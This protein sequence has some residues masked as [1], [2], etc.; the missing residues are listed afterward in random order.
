MCLLNVPVL[1]LCSYCSK[2]RSYRKA[3]ADTHV[4][5]C[6]VAACL[7]VNARATPSH[8]KPFVT[9]GFSVTYSIS[10]KLTNSQ[11]LTEANATK[12][13]ATKIAAQK[14][15]V[16]KTDARFGVRAISVIRANPTRKNRKLVLKPYPP[17]LHFR[18]KVRNDIQKALNIACFFQHSLPGKGV[19]SLAQTR[20]ANAAR[21]VSFPTYTLRQSGVTTY[22]RLEA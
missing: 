13:I 21:T 20:V 17:K 14:K 6:Q 8:V 12:V 11:Y 19:G 22:L 5:G 4:S 16:C 9:Y 2:T 18:L 15:D 7:V 3:L 1:V 10:S